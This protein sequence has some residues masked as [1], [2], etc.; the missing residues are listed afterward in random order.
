[1]TALKEYDLMDD[2]K[3]LF[4]FG[5]SQGS[6]AIN[7]SA[8]GMVKELNDIQVLWQTGTRQYEQLKHHESESVRVRPFIDDMKNAYA[9]ADLTLS[10]SGAITIAEITACGLPS[11][12]IPLP[13]SAADHQ[14]HNAKA[15]EEKG[16]AKM[17]PESK[18]DSKN[19][20]VLINEL[21]NNEHTL[22]TM[23]EN[24]KA[25]GKPEAVSVI[26]DHILEKVGA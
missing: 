1:M 10:R 19:L 13:S 7:R 16:A 17:L 5:G 25:F 11:V 20:T 6:A 9:M 26:V 14:T 15:L 23:S 3:T 12:L 24:S 18:M 21:I 8:K 22:N 2:K 4:I